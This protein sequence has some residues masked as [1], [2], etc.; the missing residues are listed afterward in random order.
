ML[1]IAPLYDAASNVTANATAVG[2][3]RALG[4]DEFANLVSANTIADAILVGTGSLT[5]F[6]ARSI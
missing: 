4:A 5:F 1:R 3:S 6:R 2:L